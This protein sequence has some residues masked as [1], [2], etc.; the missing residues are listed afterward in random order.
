MTVEEYSRSSFKPAREYRH[1]VSTEKPIAAWKHAHVQM[2]LGH[3]ILSRNPNF[4][5]ASELTCR[6]SD[7]RYLVPD[8]A[9][10]RREDV[11]DPYPT[12]PVHLC[13]E[14]L[15]PDDRLSDVIAKCEEYRAW[16]VPVVW[17]VD[18]ANQTAWE[19]G[20]YHRIHEVPANG[21]LTAGEIAVSLAELFAGL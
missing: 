17:I 10:Q 7:D 9:V 5:P 4:L 18:P 3:A 13:V 8:V 16:G 19:F 1:G 12:R 20:P 11:Q 15:S 6:L 2:R 14:I 21:E